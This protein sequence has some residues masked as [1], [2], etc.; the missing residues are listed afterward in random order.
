MRGALPIDYPACEGD[1]IVNVTIV[2]ALIALAAFALAGCHR[3][4][5]PHTERGAL[6]VGTPTKVDDMQ[7]RQSGGAGS[8]DLG[9]HRPQA[10]G[11]VLHLGQ[12]Q[13]TFPTSILE[14][15]TFETR[16][17]V[18][19]SWTPNS[20]P[21]NVFAVDFDGRIVWQV[22]ELKAIEF[23]GRSYVGVTEPYV[24]LG[25]GGSGVVRLFNWDGGTFVD[26][27]VETGR[28]RNNPIES[29]QQRGR[30]W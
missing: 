7:A 12:R 21:E 16:V 18:V 22:P 11:P 24:G 25:D 26:L 19:L 6:L 27:E 4:R 14:F 28:L 17:V 8:D 20:P 3:R 13:V 1:R 30:P 2:V 10:E 9:D 29:R 5:P 23:Q 15:R